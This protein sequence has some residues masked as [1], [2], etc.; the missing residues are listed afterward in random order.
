MFQA[1]VVSLKWNILCYVHS[2]HMY[3]GGGWGGDCD[4]IS[5][6]EVAQTSEDQMADIG[7]IGAESSTS[8]TRLLVITVCTSCMF[9]YHNDRKRLP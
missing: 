5:W 9:I 3:L 1:E 6:I 7:L 4:G 8:L 2:L